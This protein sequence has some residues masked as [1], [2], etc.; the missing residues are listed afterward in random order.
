MPAP[1]IR[2][3]LPH[4]HESHAVV[5]GDVFDQPFV[6]EQDLGLA[7]DVGVHGDRNDGVVVLTV[8]PVELVA[9]QLLDVA[10]ADEPWLLGADLTNIIGG[11][12]SRYHD[13]GISIRS[14]SGP[15]SSGCIHVAAGC[16]WSMDL[17]R[18]H[19]GRK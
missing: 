5:A 18:S 8:D 15:R 2:G 16:A 13:A 14:D 6:H 4:C 9:P 17:H 11:R 10:G 7:A 12:S 19:S 3:D 1:E